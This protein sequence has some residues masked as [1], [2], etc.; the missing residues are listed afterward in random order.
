MSNL[1]LFSSKGFAFTENICPDNP[2][3]PLASVQKWYQ[4]PIRLILLE[5]LSRWLFDII[6]HIIDTLTTDIAVDF[7]HIVFER[8]QICLTVFTDQVTVIHD[9]G[10]GF[11]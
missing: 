5:Q 6:R 2:I 8:E 4:E 1:V 3:L 10:F 11:S 7:S 9:L